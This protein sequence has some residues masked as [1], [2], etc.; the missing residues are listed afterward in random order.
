MDD[1]RLTYLQLIGSPFA[2]IDRPID[3]RL[4]QSIHIL[5][6]MAIHSGM[7]LVSCVVL[8]C[9][10]GA[11]DAHG[12]HGGSPGDTTHSALAALLN[13]GPGEISFSN[14]G[15]SL[16]L[17][18][19]TVASHQLAIVHWCDKCL[20]YRL[21]RAHFRRAA[22]HLSHSTQPPTI[23]S[24]FPK[25][26]D[27]ARCNLARSF[28]SP[29]L[30]YNEW[31]P[32]GRGDPLKNDPTYDYSPPVLDRVR[33]WSEGPT[34]KDKPGNDILL[35]G[36]PSK[37]K[38]SAGHIKEQQHW[39]NGGSPPQ[40]R[41]YYSPASHHHG[42]PISTNREPPTVLMPPPLNAPYIAGLTSDGFWGAAAASAS[43]RVDTQPT[44]GF[45]YRPAPPFAP[46]SG[47]KFTEPSV[48]QQS[49]TAQFLHHHREPPQQQQQSGAVGFSSNGRPQS[50][51]YLTTIRLTTP[52]GDTSIVKRPLLKTI[53][54]N[55][56][57][58]P[59]TKTSMTSAV[60]EYTSTFYDPQNINAMAQTVFHP[61]QT[62]EYLQ[63]VPQPTKL[64]PQLS[65]DLRTPYVTP[66]APFVTP[67]PTQATSTGRPASHGQLHPTV[68]PAVS[69]RAAA[70]PPPPPLYLIIEGHSKV[71][72]YGLNTN[73]TLMQ[74]PRMVPVASTKDPI[75]RHVVNQD[76]ETGAA[77]AVTTQQAVTTKLPPVYRKPTARERNTAAD[78]KAPDAV[79]TLLTLLDGA[80]FGG[81]LQ[82]DGRPQ[83]A[84]TTG[85]NALEGSDAASTRDSKTRRHVRVARHTFMRF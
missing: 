50:Q 67:L 24:Q 37:N 14:A 58:Y 68:K 74:L 85:N 7:L 77:M 21:Q 46:Q 3:E 18:A 59:F 34:G 12:Y 44:D 80:S 83:D 49:I 25:R 81:I 16:N 72:T 45:K 57:S 43:Q 53:L 10:A 9:T 31:L 76:P 5:R 56:H 71:K 15:S 54:Q 2:I 84:G 35:L 55:E 28:H 26:S 22:H 61:P 62:T 48:P 79:D 41:N 64:V 39:N 19:A 42:A 11:T 70:P 40:R 52:A 6:K 38:A 73:D 63:T 29:R 33:Y 30:E 78:Q 32:V 1:H 27:N 69:D 75:V 8:I 66:A 82:D 4:A 36:V 17:A 20:N 65:T 60:T 23:A 13:D 47:T 51:P